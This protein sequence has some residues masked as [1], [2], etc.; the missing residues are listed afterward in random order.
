[1]DFGLAEAR[2]AAAK[3]GGKRVSTI[4]LGALLE[5]WHEE[6]VQTTY[7]R[8]REVSQY[9]DRIEPAL[10]TT[11]LRNISTGS[12]FARCSSDTR[13]NAARSQ[14]IGSYRF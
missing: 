7:R 8:P 13:T 9:F 3:T 10:R 11:K 2:V 5:T 4:T 12:P 1:V 6:I 14:P